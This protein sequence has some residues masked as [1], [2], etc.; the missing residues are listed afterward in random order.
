MNLAKIKNVKKQLVPKKIKNVQSFLGLGNYNRKFIKDYS[1]K[2]LLLTELT[3]K[4]V[5]FKQEK[6]QQ[7]AFKDV[8]I[9]YLEELTL[10]MFDSKRLIQIKTDISDRVLGAC[11][12]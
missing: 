4:D 8:K 11:I 5:K 12:I 10:K 7:T 2:T 1:K 6:E 9:A 3:K